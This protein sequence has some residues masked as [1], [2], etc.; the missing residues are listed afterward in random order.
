VSV[1]PCASSERNS[2]PPEKFFGIVS[3]SEFSKPF[4]RRHSEFGSDRGTRKILVMPYRTVMR[5]IGFHSVR[6]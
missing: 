3:P 2:N 1:R 5:R 6:T 4:V